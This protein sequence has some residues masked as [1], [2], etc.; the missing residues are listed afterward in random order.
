MKTTRFLGLVCLSLAVFALPTAAPAAG[1]ST[2]ARDDTCDNLKGAKPGLYG[3]C[4]AMCEA[5]DCEGIYDPEYDRVTFD[6]SCKPSSEKLF[7][8]F[9]KLAGNTGVT[10]S[11]IRVPCPCWT[12]SEIDNVGGG[13]FFGRS[14]DLCFTSGNS[15]FL[16][17]VAKDGS[18]QELAYALETSDGLRCLRMET[19][20]HTDLDMQIGSE[21]FRTCRDSVIAECISRGMMKP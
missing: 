1:G 7:R 21:P 15:V 20:T 8:N 4:V 5:Q 19:D 13:V 14:Q 16:N 10:P 2:P 17:G 18:G 9:Q 6:P 3:L 12:E 11:C